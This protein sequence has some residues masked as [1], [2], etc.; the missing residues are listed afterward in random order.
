VDEISKKYET[1]V[2]ILLNLTSGYLSEMKGLTEE[3]DELTEKY[4]AGESVDYKSFSSPQARLKVLQRKVKECSS[5][6][7][8]LSPKIEYEESDFTDEI[9]RVRYRAEVSE[10]LV[11]PTIPVGET[12]NWSIIVRNVGFET[13]NRDNCKLVISI[14]KDDIFYDEVY[15]CLIPEGENIS[16]GEY[17]E[18]SFT[19]SE[20]PSIGIYSVSIYG[21]NMSGYKMDKQYAYSLYVVE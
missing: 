13:W 5:T 15:E 20:F 16:T 4:L 10:I 2:K 7:S 11:S 3:I 8:S 9:N 6:I 19:A 21:D 14:K 18:F 1:Q 12:S 17:K